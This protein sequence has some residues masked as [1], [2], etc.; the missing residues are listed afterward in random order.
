M[1]KHRSN[2]TCYECHRK[3]D[4]IGLGLEEFDHVGRFRTKYSK[5]LPIDASGEMPDGTK[6]DGVG[7]IKHYLLARPQQFARNLAAKMMTYALGRR[8]AF[9]D[10]ADTDQIVSALR[11]KGYGLRDL[12]HAVT[13]SEAFRSK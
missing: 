3:I 10:R 7:G 1:E 8:L 12:I 11:E 9:T 4:P 13:Q 2:P 5:K 6:F